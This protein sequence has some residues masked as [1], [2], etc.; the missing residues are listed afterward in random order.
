MMEEKFESYVVRVS[1]RMGKRISFF[2][3]EDYIE[4]KE[5]IE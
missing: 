3:S 1:K 4:W 2:W 5:E